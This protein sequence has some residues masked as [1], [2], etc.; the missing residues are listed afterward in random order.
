MAGSEQAAKNS[1]ANLIGY[2]FVDP[3]SL[4][5][6][7]LESSFHPDHNVYSRRGNIAQGL[8]LAPSTFVSNDRPLKGSSCPV[9][10]EDYEVP[11][12]IGP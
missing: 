7:D 12:I 1:L 3:R 4:K 2:G 9:E 6:C 5:S 11:R 10:S 8:R